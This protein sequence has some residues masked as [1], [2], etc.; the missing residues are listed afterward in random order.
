MGVG[1]MPEAGCVLKARENPASPWQLWWGSGVDRGQ[2]EKCRPGLQAHDWDSLA[3]PPWLWGL[4]RI[5][6]WGW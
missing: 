6:S 5:L 4:F 1:L 2:G 3:W